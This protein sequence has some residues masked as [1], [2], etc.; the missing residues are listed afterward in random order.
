MNNFILILTH[1]QDMEHGWVEVPATLMDR[2]GILEQVSEYSYFSF[3]RQAYYLEEDG[4]ASLLI[5]ALKSQGLE[6]VLKSK[7]YASRAPMR[8]MARVGS[9]E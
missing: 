5:K 1:H 9:A 6:Y 3:D 8:R 7:N 2:L 4:D